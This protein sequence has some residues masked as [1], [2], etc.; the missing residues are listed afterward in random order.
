MNRKKLLSDPPSLFLLLPVPCPPGDVVAVLQC[1]NN[2][3]R[4]KWQPSRGADF[5]IVEA[6]GMEEHV[7]GCETNTQSCILDDLKCGFTYNISVIAVNSVCN[8]SQSDE[9]QLQAGKDKQRN[10]TC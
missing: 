3:A 7:S 10:L 2:T 4:V 6:F 8:V 5:Y 1:S 9:I